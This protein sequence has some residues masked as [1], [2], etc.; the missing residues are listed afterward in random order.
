MI[1]LFFQERKEVPLFLLTIHNLTQEV[2]YRTQIQWAVWLQLGDNTTGTAVGKC[3]CAFSAAAPQR[4][5]VLHGIRG[6]RRAPTRQQD[7]I[8][9]NIWKKKKKPCMQSVIYWVWH[10]RVVRDDALWW[11]RGLWSW[12]KASVIASSETVGKLGTW[13]GFMQRLPPQTISPFSSHVSDLKRKK[14]WLRSS[15]SISWWL[16]K[17]RLGNKDF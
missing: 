3:S 16:N 15:A 17:R 4:T 13:G 11:R 12:F 14:N 1:E 7:V 9:W 5:E 6:R 10:Q 8:L 2:A